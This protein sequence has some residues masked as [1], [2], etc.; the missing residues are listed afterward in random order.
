MARA[1]PGTVVVDGSIPDRR[2]R[3]RRMAGGLC[4]DRS[5]IE[6]VKEAVPEVSNHEG[7]ELVDAREP[8]P[9]DIEDTLPLGDGIADSISI[10]WV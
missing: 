4:S 5:L 1:R 7:T 6:E 10:D 3:G 8:K 9:A 2:M